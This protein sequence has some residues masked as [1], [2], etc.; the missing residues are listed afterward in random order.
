MQHFIIIKYGDKIPGNDAM[1]PSTNVVQNK[2]YHARSYEYKALDNTW[3]YEN[4]VVCV[5]EKVSLP[6]HAQGASR[7][8]FTITLASENTTLAAK[9]YRKASK[10]RLKN[11]FADV[12]GQTVARYYSR[13]IF[14][15]HKAHYGRIDISEAKH[16]QIYS[17]HTRNEIIDFFN[18]EIHV[19][20]REFVRFSNNTS[21][22]SQTI[23][24]TLSSAFSHYTH[25]KSE[26]KL[27][28][29]DLQGW[30]NK[31]GDEREFIH[32][33]DPAIHSVVEK[34]TGFF[35]PGLNWG[36]EGFYKFWNRQ[37]KTCNHLCKKMGL[38]IP[39]YL[40]PKLDIVY[41]LYLNKHKVNFVF[42]SPSSTL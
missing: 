19:T 36:L 25:D 3:R 16:L 27:I 41:Y 17:N 5:K 32:L 2:W 39:T 10:H 11:Y 31:S 37:H 40:K 20:D 34:S 4:C 42:D 13:Q 21:Y 1:V 26:G 38:T 9:H 15:D 14:F 28:V 6:D 22:V 29:V 24:T 7:D 35:T 33:T 8:L 18:Y 30:K 12:R 23:N